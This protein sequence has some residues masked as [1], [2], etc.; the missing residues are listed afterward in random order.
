M[1]Y[2]WHLRR[3]RRDATDVEITFTAHVDGTL[4]TIVHSGWERLGAEGSQW[5]DRNRQG[6]AGLLPHY[7]RACVDRA[8]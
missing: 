5:R 3:D 6:W 2:L 8:L 7:Q 1:R 4:V